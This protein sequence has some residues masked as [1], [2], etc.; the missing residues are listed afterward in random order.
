MSSFRINRSARTNLGFFLTSGRDDVAPFEHAVTKVA[1]EVANG[2]LKE[3][4]IRVRNF[5]ENLVLFDEAVVGPTKTAIQDA[6]NREN[7]FGESD[8]KDFLQSLSTE[9]GAFSFASAIAFACMRSYHEDIENM[10]KDRE[11]AK[12]PKN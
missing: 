2:A 11:P 9:S 6:V 7:K 3:H 4:K 8:N 12:R 1:C 5:R 10:M